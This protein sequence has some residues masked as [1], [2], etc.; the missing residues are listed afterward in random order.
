M[1]VVHAVCCRIEGLG[2]LGRE[3]ARWV[4]A[5]TDGLLP[6]RKM[7]SSWRQGPLHVG[8]D[9]RVGFPHSSSV[10]VAEWTQDS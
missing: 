5:M 10:P 1:H 3:L 8:H 4:L 6:C 9:E 7:P 2:S